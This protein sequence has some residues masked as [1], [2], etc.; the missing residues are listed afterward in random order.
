MGIGVLAGVTG[1]AGKIPFAETATEVGK[2]MDAK[3]RADAFEKMMTDP[4]S[5]GLVAWIAAHTDR[6]ADGPIARKP[7]SSPLGEG[8][9]EHFE[10]N[11]PIFRGNLRTADEAKDESKA[12]AKEAAHARTIARPSSSHSIRPH[13]PLHR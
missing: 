8:L 12:A 6:D 7:V 1:G 2:L 10:A 4:F 3:T 13:R 9:K 5:V 11:Y